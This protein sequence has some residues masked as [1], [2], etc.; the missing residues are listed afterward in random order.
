MKINTDRTDS[1]VL[2]SSAECRPPLLSTHVFLVSGSFNIDRATMGDVRNCVIK[3]LL[4][5]LAT[6]TPSTSG[7]S[8]SELSSFEFN[9][10]FV[11][12]FL[13]VY[14]SLTVR[15]STDLRH[16]HDHQALSMATDVG[17]RTCP[18]PSDK[19]GHQVTKLALWIY[20][21]TINWA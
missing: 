5:T 19:H 13:T 12:S 18:H 15:A 7:F 17:V 11:V 8:Y 6:V 2:L 9:A 4:V 3:G 20:P 16:E 1:A 14:S 21:L 10:R